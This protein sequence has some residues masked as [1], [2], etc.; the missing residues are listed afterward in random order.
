M[1]SEIKKLIIDNK[2]KLGD[3]PFSHEE[4]KV[5]KFFHGSPVTNTKLLFFVTLNDKPLCILKMVRDES[6]NGVIVRESTGIEY[7]RSIDVSTPKIFFTGEI[8]NLK[9]LCQEIIAGCPVGQDKQESLIPFVIDFHNKA[10]KIKELHVSDILSV[11][12]GLE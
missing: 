4:L 5:S 11:L 10:N 7:L 2:E 1:I 12:Q 8:N 6:D 3:V 9:F